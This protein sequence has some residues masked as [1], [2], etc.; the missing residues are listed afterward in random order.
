MTN[1]QKYKEKFRKEA[2]EKYQNFSKEKKSKKR[3]KVSERCQ[4]VTERVREKNAPMSL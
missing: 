4:N 1:N 2:H 3:K